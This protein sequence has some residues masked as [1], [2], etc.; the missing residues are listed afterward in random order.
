MALAFGVLALQ[1]QAFA[2]Q[3]V[4]KPPL[5]KGTVDF[6]ASGEVFYPRAGAGMTY[7]FRAV[8]PG[9]RM[10]GTRVTF[11]GTL[12]YAFEGYSQRGDPQ[13]EC[14]HKGSGSWKVQA[15]IYQ[16]GG[17]GDPS[18]LA[19]VFYD[20]PITAVGATGRVIKTC[21]LLPVPEERTGR[22][23]F[24]YLL[25][26]IKSMSTTLRSQTRSFKRTIRPEVIWDPLGDY[27]KGTATLTFTRT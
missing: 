14:S 12:T 2:R 23:A 15:S 9:K 10:R 4:T 13:G 1:G 7:T 17:E 27:I 22:E 24:R 3:G 20:D 8:F 18:R 25:P 5:W 11:V 6:K 16:A 21:P 26:G 19:V